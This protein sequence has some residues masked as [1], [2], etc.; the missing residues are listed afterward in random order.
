MV[1]Y[2]LR[3]KLVVVLSALFL[4]L[5]ACSGDDGD[6]GVN[7]ARAVVDDA[8]TLEPAAAN[9]RAATDEPAATGNLDAADRGE[10]LQTDDGNPVILGAPSAPT[11][12]TV[13]GTADGTIDLVWDA[14]RDSDVTR[15]RVLRS[16]SGSASQQ[17]EVTGTSFSDVGL[18]DGD[19]FS[20]RVIA[21][22]E[23]FDSPASESVIARVGVDTNPPRRPGQPAVEETP[24]GQILT[25]SPV[26]DVSGISRYVITRTVGGVET[27]IDVGTE[28]EFTD[29][30]PAGTVV[31][32]NVLAIDGA[33]NVSE[34]SRSTT[35]LTGTP[36]NRVAVVVSAQAD[37]AATAG[38]ARFERDLLAAGFTISWFEDGVFDSNVTT[39]DDIVILLG[40]VE[41]NGFDWNVFLS[42]ATVIGLKSPFVAAGGFTENPLPTDRV[43]TIGYTA[44]GTAQRFVAITGTSEPKPIPLLN[45]SEQLPDLDVWATPDYSAEI[46][47]AG[48]IPAGGELANGREAPGCRAFYPGNTDA[49]IEMSEA[50]WGLLIDFIG[51]VETAC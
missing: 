41:G 13:V 3:R 40:D 22:R 30:L 12:L 17:F 26:E 38:T 36:A 27:N 11:G 39:S 24:T 7:T 18:D 16:A 9:E 8:L 14:S 31:T 28:P 15:Y 49:F 19:V 42:D 47:I 21:L 10:V 43:Q 37:P 29:D 6:G 35:L 1:S 51:D 23:N 45:P 2:F 5:A 25:W 33:N 4:V 34:A 20:Y 50:G 44:P 48:I 32:Y 46:A